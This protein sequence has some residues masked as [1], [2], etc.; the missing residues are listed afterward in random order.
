[1][2]WNSK[3]ACQLHKSWSLKVS[4]HG[5]QL[6]G[7]FSTSDFCNSHGALLIHLISVTWTT[8][9]SCGWSV[10][11]IYSQITTIYDTNA[12]KWSQF[13]FIRLSSYSHFLFS[14]RFGFWNSKLFIIPCFIYRHTPHRSMCI[15][16]HH[17]HI[18]VFLYGSV[19][20]LN[21]NQVFHT[22]KRKE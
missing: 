3:V 22:Y 15:F 8:I 7:L 13:M 20:I 19:C 17:T 11:K 21:A 18:Y 14:E 2:S 9:C 6:G 5:H 4:E 1:M 16:T 10:F 12:F